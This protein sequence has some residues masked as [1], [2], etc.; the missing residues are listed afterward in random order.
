MLAGSQL[1]ELQKLIP[2]RSATR[3][4]EMHSIGHPHESLQLRWVAAR[5]P[6]RLKDGSIH[7][8][9]VFEADWRGLTGEQAAV[10]VHC[11]IS[12]K[13]LRQ[14][15]AD[16]GESIQATFEKLLPTKA[17]LRSG[18]FGEMLTLAALEA[19]DAPLLFPLPRWQLRP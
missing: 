17:G 11:Y 8:A 3:M 15:A 6:G 13:R 2:K 4:P 10:I 1:L 9:E 14:L 18:D 12:P 7:R 19:R 16:G 5:R